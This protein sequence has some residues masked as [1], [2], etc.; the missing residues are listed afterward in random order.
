MLSGTRIIVEKAALLLIFVS[1]LC[2]IFGRAVAI[3]I[4][5]ID[6]GHGGEDWG[7]IGVQGTREKDVT[8]EIARQLSEIIQDRMGAEAV[9]TRTNDSYIGLF[10]R[11]GIAN[12]NKAEIL[13]SLHANSA[14]SDGQTGQVM[15]FFVHG[16]TSDVKD[17]RDIGAGNFI[18]TKDKEEAKAILWDMVQTRLH[19]ESYRLANIIA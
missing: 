6:P 18:D 11:T 13:I 16:Q 8:L 12:H 1:L 14:F 17:E 15:I 5:A 19:N 9:L 4:V 7:C 10:E 2:P 3:E